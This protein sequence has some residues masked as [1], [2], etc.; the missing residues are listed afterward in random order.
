MLPAKIH[1]QPALLL[2]LWPLA[3]LLSLDS[4]WG[5]VMPSC[6]PFQC[7][8]QDAPDW[9]LLQSSSVVFSFPYPHRVLCYCGTHL[10]LFPPMNHCSVHVLSAIPQKEELNLLGQVSMF[11]KEP[12]WIWDCIMG[13]YFPTPLLIQLYG[14]HWILYHVHFKF[15]VT[16]GKKFGFNI[17]VIFKKAFHF[18]KNKTLP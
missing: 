12:S 8:A 5:S 15:W 13:M 18:Y 2:K 16:S 3:Q 6:L 7:C 9:T 4:E 10:L 14:G 17:K 1:V 11:W